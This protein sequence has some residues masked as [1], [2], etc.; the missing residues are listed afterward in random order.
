MPK[1]DAHVDQIIDNQQD[2]TVETK[3]VSEGLVDVTTKTPTDGD[4]SN[5][6]DPIVGDGDESD[7]RDP[8]LGDED[9]DASENET[10]V[11]EDDDQDDWDLDDYEDLDEDFRFKINPTA[12][13]N[14]V[15]YNSLDYDGIED[16]DDY[17]NE[18]DFT[19]YEDYEDEVEDEFEDDDDSHGESQIKV[20]KPSTNFTNKKVF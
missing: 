13:G 12:N 16:E 8:I 2:G 19:D 17:S 15:V 11:G 18:D 1:T 6:I 4:E 14:Y 9:E 10:D 3:T 7:D 5:D 20:E